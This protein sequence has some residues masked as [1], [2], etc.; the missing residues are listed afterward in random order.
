[1]KSDFSN[2]VLSLKAFKYVF[3]T[4]MSH[5]IPNRLFALICSCISFGEIQPIYAN[6]KRHKAVT[7]I[8][9]SLKKASMAL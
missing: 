6:F 2:N 7:D 1:M 3:V 8:P 4:N 5:K 9:S